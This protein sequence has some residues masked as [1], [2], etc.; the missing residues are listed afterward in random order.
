M[1]IDFE[2]HYLPEGF[3]KGPL[4]PGIGDI[5]E[6]LHNMDLAG[7]DVAVL[8]VHAPM[9]APSTAECR[10]LNDALSQLQLKHPKRLVG[11]VHTR[12]QDATEAVAEL[13]RGVKALGLKGVDMTAQPG[14]RPVDD[15][16]LW[17]FYQKVQELGVPI[18]IHCST[19]PLVGFSALDAPYSIERGLGWE[20][21]L[22]TCTTRLVMGAVLKDFP[23]LKIVV[24]HFGGGISSIVERLEG[25]TGA[26]Q[27][28][29][30]PSS[31]KTDRPFRDGLSMLYFDMAGCRGGMGAV[32]AALTALRPAQ[33]VFA[34]DYPYNFYNKPDEIKK[35][36]QNIR[37]LSIS[38][39]SIAGMLGTNAARI[40][41]ILPA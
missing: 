9:Y 30:G 7:I 31:G 6:H 4:P 26:R 16:A 41:K 12:P 5:E 25:D 19:G 2:H 20:L 23:E 15:P 35:Y 32:Q 13:D 28:S 17:P 1:I 39:D 14:G 27:A 36:V 21:E 34:T 33:L 10:A 38:K 8:S 22:M 37:N 18:Y 3:K 40:L 29:P 24:S 11:L